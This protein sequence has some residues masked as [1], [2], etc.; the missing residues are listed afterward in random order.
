MSSYGKRGYERSGPLEDQD[1]KRQKY[2]A[3]H[4]IPDSGG[5]RNGGRSHGRDGRAAA[6]AE[7]AQ[8]KDWLSKENDFVLKQAKKRAAIRVRE[9]RAKPVDY[10]A[11]NLRFV[12]SERD[13]TEENELEEVQ[14]SPKDPDTY[15]HSLHPQEL[16]ELEQDIDDF[17]RLETDRKNRDYWK[18]LK[19]A[20]KD[21]Q[22]RQKQA[23]TSE[24][25][26]SNTVGADIDRI[27]ANKTSDQLIAL[28][29]SINDKLDSRAPIDVDYWQQLL[30][31]VKYKQA[32]A[33][34]A[35]MHKLIVKAAEEE[36]QRKQVI[37]RNGK[38]TAAEPAK[39]VT[40][41]A[42]ASS[43]KSGQST[44][45]DFETAAQKLYR[46]EAASQLKEDEELFNVESIRAAKRPPKWLPKFPSIKPV[47]PKFFNRVYVGVDWTAYNKAHY[48]SEDPPPK[49]IWGYRFNIFYPDL[50]DMTK[51]PTYRIERQLGLKS[52]GPGY[53]EDMCFLRFTAGPPYDDVVFEVVDKDWDNSSRFG[54]FKSSFERGKLFLS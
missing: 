10:L 3:H 20:C 32:W 50:L 39:R 5:A 48:T 4:G 22:A 33:R 21:L 53:Q 12:D 23:K 34:L 54:G 8:M 24:A 27:L 31:S 11:V 17:Y 51:T 49:T 37:F 19:V 14:I 18:A 29:H 7:A 6:I 25:R 2:N 40:L 26:T 15:L 1:A 38:R 13:P 47:K 9:A 43:L 35:E 36:S 41:D 46:Q 30:Q 52:E 45:L 28:E 16:D 44:E 42:V